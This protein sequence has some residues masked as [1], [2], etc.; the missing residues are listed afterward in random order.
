VL[1]ATRRAGVFSI[2]T[3]FGQLTQL[4]A[5]VEGKRHD[6]LV[7]CGN[8]R[9]ENNREVVDLL[10]HGAG[11]FVLVRPHAIANR[12][13]VSDQTLPCCFVNGMASSRNFR[14]D[15]EALREGKLDR[16]KAS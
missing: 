11:A 13:Q 6:V 10:E 8:G 12:G 15:K 2:G 7:V 5:N 3:T 9:S 14:A 1:L 4:T 16:D